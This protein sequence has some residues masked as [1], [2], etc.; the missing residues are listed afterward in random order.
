MA[1]VELALWRN[2]PP[3]FDG[4]TQQWRTRA[5][6]WVDRN[7]ITGRY[8]LARPPSI[9]ATLLTLTWDASVDRA[10]AEAILD[11]IA[12]MADPWDPDP[13]EMPDWRNPVDA[14]VGL[15]DLLENLGWSVPD[16]SECGLG[17]DSCECAMPFVPFGW[18]EVS[19]V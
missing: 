17:C 2:W 5:V 9:T 8:T 11:D 19:Q 10:T 13:H 14:R 15:L 1:E 6:R 16:F 3:L 12:I 4:E 18:G 7:V